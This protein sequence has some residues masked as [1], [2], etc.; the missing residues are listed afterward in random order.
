MLRLSVAVDG[1]PILAAGG[2]AL[3]TF[4]SSLSFSIDLFIFAIYSRGGICYS[5]KYY[6][7]RT[8]KIGGMAVFCGKKSKSKLEVYPFISKDIYIYIYIS[9]YWYESTSR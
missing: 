7:T 8:L 5:Q 6:L 9:I 2:A 3:L 4:Y 1:Q